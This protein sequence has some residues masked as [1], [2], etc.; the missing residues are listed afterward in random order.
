LANLRE[1]YDAKDGDDSG[2]DNTSLVRTTWTV[3]AN[4]AVEASGEGDDGGE[5]TSAQEQVPSEDVGGDQPLTA[6]GNH[7][8]TEQRST[9]LAD[10]L[11]KQLGSP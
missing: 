10:Q 3:A 4:V 7:I 8:E 5:G 9:S 1:S 6:A 11:N 2:G